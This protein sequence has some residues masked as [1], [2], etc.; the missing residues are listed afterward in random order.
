VGLGGGGLYGLG[1]EGCGKSGEG[2]G[3]VTADGNMRKK[4]T[5]FT[6]IR[7]ISILKGA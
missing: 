3:G 4:G 1:E 7:P 2:G 5:R 6:C